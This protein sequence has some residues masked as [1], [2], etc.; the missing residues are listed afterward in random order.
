MTTFQELDAYLN[1]EFSDDYWYDDAKFY[2][3]ELVKQLTANDWNAIKSSWQNRS[4]QWQV[5]FA[6]ILDWGEARQVVPLLRQ[7]IQVRDDELMLTAADSLRSLLG[8]VN[9]NLPGGEDILKHLQAIAQRGYIPSSEDVLHLQAVAQTGNIARRIINELAEKSENFNE[10]IEKLLTDLRRRERTR[11]ADRAILEAVL[12]AIDSPSFPQEQPSK[13]LIHL[14]VFIQGMDWGNLPESDWDVMSDRYDLEAVDAVFKGMIAV[15]EIAPQRLAAE[16][17]WV[18][19][20]NKRIPSYDLDAIEAALKD[21][22]NNS[23]GFAWALEQ[24]AKFLEDYKGSS[25]FGK[26]PQVPV[27]RRWERAKEAQ[28]SPKI[29]ERALEHPS[30]GI[31]QNAALLLEALRA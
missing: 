10:L 7:M 25:L 16:A 21:T 3:C 27:E 11:D 8:V 5:R 17:A 28:L 31:V 30:E 9:L 22:E 15:L 18:L 23:Q 14:G 1:Q 2:A 6:E 12:R 13:E 26:I 24:I 19:E 4:K 29:L 20:D